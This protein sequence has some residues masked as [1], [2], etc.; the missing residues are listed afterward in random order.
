MPYH[1]GLDVAVRKHNQD[2]FARDEADVVV[3]TVAF[4]M[5]IDK[6]NV[7]FVI[8]AGM[9]KSLEAFQQESGRAGRDGLE[10][11]CVLFYSGGD[12]QKWKQI[13]ETGQ[14]QSP[15]ALTALNAMY[16][17]CTGADCRHRPDT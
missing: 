7:R 5:G 11:E 1:A 3:A 10:A 15:G 2:A 6:S 14:Q 4:G 16:A 13:I 17:F 8:H 9:P 12:W